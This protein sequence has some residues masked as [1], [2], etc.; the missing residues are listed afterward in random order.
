MKTLKG[1]LAIILL[2]TLSALWTLPIPLLVG[3]LLWPI[4][5]PII[6]I[7][8]WGFLMGRDC[9]KRDSEPFDDRVQDPKPV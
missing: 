8:L 6:A 4:G 5:G 2:V 7:F 9:Y 3:F 1:V